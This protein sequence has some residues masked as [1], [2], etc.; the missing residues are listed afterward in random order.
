MTTSSFNFSYQPHKKGLSQVL[1]ELEAPIMDYIWERGSA[2]VREVCD[3]LQADQKV[4]YTTVMTVMSRL[5]DKGLLER[6]KSGQAFVYTAA[7]TKA[8]FTS[9]TVGRIF[10]ALIGEWGTPVISSLLDSVERASPER[11]D[12]LAKLIEERRK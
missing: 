1:G 4:A 8:A 12:E 3:H 9:D 11:M 2:S 7:Q 5:A 10:S 6:C